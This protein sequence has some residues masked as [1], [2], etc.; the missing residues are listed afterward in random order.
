MVAHSAAKLESK[1]QS[2]NH[3]ELEIHNETA[4]SVDTVYFNNTE[5]S[6]SGAIWH[7]ADCHVNSM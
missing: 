3:G 2:T 7:A 6:Y 1:A 4:S 5:Q